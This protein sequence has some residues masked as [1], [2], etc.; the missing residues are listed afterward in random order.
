MT[1]NNFSHH[2]H[3]HDYS[4]LGVLKAKAAGQNK[5]LGP[6]KEVFQPLA[7]AAL[8][9]DFPSWQAARDAMIAQSKASKRGVGV[10]LNDGQ[11]MTLSVS[12]KNVVSL[13]TKNHAA[14]MDSHTGSFTGNTAMTEE[15]ATVCKTLAMSPKARAKAAMTM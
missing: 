7:K 9:K 6:M 12:D 2:G 10:Q 8:G 1:H 3:T 14:V 11:S 15:A 5:D 13:S 4:V